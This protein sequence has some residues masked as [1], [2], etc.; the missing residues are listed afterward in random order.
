MTQAV[1]DHAKE[2]GHTS[3]TARW[4]PDFIHPLALPGQR[5]VFLTFTCNGQ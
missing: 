4:T 3:G 2:A 5:N 1:P